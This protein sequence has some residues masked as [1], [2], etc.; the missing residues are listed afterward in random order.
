MKERQPS[1]VCGRDVLF[2]VV[3][4]VLVQFAS[5]LHVFSAP[6]MFVVVSPRNRKKFGTCTRLPQTG[7]CFQW[8]GEQCTTRG[9]TVA[10]RFSP[11][12]RAQSI[13][14]RPRGARD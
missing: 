14:L 8:I 9:T 5:C 6:A 3:Y 2:L 12:P 11:T 4:A 7:G 13:L 1:Y 10:L